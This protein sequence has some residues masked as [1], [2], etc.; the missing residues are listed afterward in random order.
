MST[1][2]EKI[3]DRLKLVRTVLSLNQKEF[4]SNSGV[5][6]STYQ[7]YEMGMS[8]PGGEAIEGFIRLGINANWLLTGEGEKFLVNHQLQQALAID[9]P[10]LVKLVEEMDRAATQAGV[11]IPANDKGE[12]IARSYAD[13]IDAM[14]HH[15]SRLDAAKVAGGYFERI[16]AQYKIE[17]GK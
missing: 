1:P 13:I 9:V 2:I 15:E 5:G 17:K 3:S 12:M 11:T 7:K 16:A 10:L 8:I 4:A 14:S 6:F